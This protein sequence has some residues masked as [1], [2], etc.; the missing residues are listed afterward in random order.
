MLL[1]LATVSTTYESRNRK[2]DENDL[3]EFRKRGM[4]S[5]TVVVET[6]LTLLLVFTFLFGIMEAAR[7]F[8]VQNTLT[9]AAREGARLSVAPLTNTS[10]LATPSEVRDRV[11]TFLSAAGITVPDSDIVVE[12]DVTIGT[13]TYTR[14]TVTAKYEL[15][16]FSFFGSLTT[17]NLQ[18]KAL[19]R[20]ET[21]EETGP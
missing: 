15:I 18:A 11:R 7:L 2:P 6:A 13:T 20:N 19:M 17:G 3:M 1:L 9:D 5:G 14:V 21:S 16:T 4:E 12:Q 8:H 10:Q